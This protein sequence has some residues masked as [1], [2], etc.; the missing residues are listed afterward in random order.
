MYVCVI[1]KRSFLSAKLN[2]FK[3]I[4]IHLT[5]AKYVKRDKKRN[6]L[7]DESPDFNL[8]AGLV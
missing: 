7:K 1:T 6:S 2:V 4:N 5:F 8:S 3:K